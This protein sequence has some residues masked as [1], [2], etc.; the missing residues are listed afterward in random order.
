MST[1]LFICDVTS[2][3][4]KARTCSG[5]AP[6][7]EELFVLVVAGYELLTPMDAFECSKFV[8]EYRGSI[9][10]EETAHWKKCAAEGEYGL[11]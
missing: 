3:I 10:V 7:T 8:T 1:V 4:L 5:Q 2:I 11:S 9:S 6:H